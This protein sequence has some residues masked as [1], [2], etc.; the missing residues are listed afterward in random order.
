MKLYFTYKEIW[1]NKTVRVQRER[2]V[3]SAFFTRTQSRTEVEILYGSMQQQR[4]QQQHQQ[5]TEMLPA[6]A[7]SVAKVKTPAG[8][9]SSSR[10][11]DSIVGGDN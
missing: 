9:S 10:N 7:I 3:G 2:G 4:R 1:G 8:N 6:T 11:D 5:I